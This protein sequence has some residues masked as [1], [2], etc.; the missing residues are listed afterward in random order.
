V[1][2][3]SQSRE[4]L[5]LEECIAERDQVAAQIREV[6]IFIRQSSE[7]VEKLRRQ[8]AEIENRV[9]QMEANFD[10]IPRADIPN[11]Y[12]A[13]R[14]ATGRLF[15]MEGQLDKLQ[16]DRE[17]LDQRRELL[18][19]IIEILQSLS[20]RSAATSSKDV[21]FSPEQ[22]MVVRIIEAQENE[23]LRLSRQMHDG[24]AQHLTNV[25]LQ[26]EI[27]QRLLDTDPARARVELEKLKEEVNNTFQRT[28][29]FISDLRPMM[30]DDLGLVPT[31]KRYVASWSEKTGI[32]SDLAV[33]GKEHRL[34]SYTEVT[35]FRAVQQ[36]VENAERHANPSN[37]QVTLELNGQTARAIVEDDG[38]GFDIDEV[39]AAADARKT[40]G[41][42]SIMDR[43]QMLGGSLKYD[44]VRGRGT[45]A[46][47]EVP[48]TS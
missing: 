46:V 45:K 30:L 22:S 24:T 1:G 7:E 3:E 38:V 20:A 10:T 17:S 13:A 9:Q 12:N 11:I 31:L 21:A 5:F 41:I 26:A 2:E 19:A 44:S 39:M 15:M 25:I 8:N 48:E 33:V 18:A 29:T 28:R 32:K 47:L 37:V 36:L 40:I 35:I 42:A 34:A 23:R 6:E 43:V 16:S 4:Q 27:C 14:K